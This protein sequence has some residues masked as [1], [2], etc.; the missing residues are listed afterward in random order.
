MFA[1]GCDRAGW[2]PT[3]SVS[4]STRKFRMDVT[5]KVP[6]E[7]SKIM[8]D[9]SGRQEGRGTTVLVVG[10]WNKGLT[11]GVWLTVE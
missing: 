8:P 10:S 3:L 5:G 11:V 4:A 1:G 6:A 9:N 2:S 7:T